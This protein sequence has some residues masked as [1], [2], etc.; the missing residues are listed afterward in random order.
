MKEMYKMSEL[1]AQLLYA[2]SEIDNK[3]I[4]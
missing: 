3:K 2:I 4:Y 1:L